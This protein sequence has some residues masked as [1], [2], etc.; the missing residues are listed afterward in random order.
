MRRYYQQFVEHCLRLATRYP[1]AN[2]QYNSYGMTGYT[3]G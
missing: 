1:K 2:D 3:N